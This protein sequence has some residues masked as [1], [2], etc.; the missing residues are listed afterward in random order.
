MLHRLVE[1]K[2]ALVSMVVS[3]LWIEWRQADSEQGY[4][5]RRLCLDEDWWRK[6]DFLLKFTTPAFELLWNA[7]TN[8]PFL[9][10]VY[11]GMDSMVEKT[12]EI[13]SQESP[14]LLFVGD[15]FADL[16]KKIIVDRWNN[17]NA[18]LHTLAHALNPKFYDEKLIAQINGKRK[19]PHKD[20]E[21]ANG[22][23]KALMR[24]F[25]SHLHRELGGGVVMEKMVYICKVA[26]SSS[27]ERN[28]STYGSIHSVKRNMLGSQKAKDLV[29]V[30]SNLRLASRRGPEYNSGPAK[31]WDVDV[32]SPDLDLS[33]VALN[34]EVQPGSGIGPSFS[35]APPS[36]VEHAFASIFYDD[37]DDED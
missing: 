30:H 9:G 17:F 19:A 20:G 28:W 13:I 8:Q 25:P 21:V 22:V 11:D 27:A 36:T 15:H 10:E 16:V 34:I 29:Y 7:N 31:E 5:V 4:M 18:P 1:V 14:Q 2:H 24:T 3:Q 26:I 32:E 37:Y 35:S 6:I 23:K 33:L 12:M